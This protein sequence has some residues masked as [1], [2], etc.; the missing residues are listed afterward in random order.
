[1]HAIVHV[2]YTMLLHSKASLHGGAA[3]LAPMMIMCK[4]MACIWL[5]NLLPWHLYRCWCPDAIFGLQAIAPVVDTVLLPSRSSV[6]TMGPIT[7][8]PAAMACM[9]QSNP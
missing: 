6:M 8:K 4:M 2:V 9:M 5:P 7:A 1:M 3:A